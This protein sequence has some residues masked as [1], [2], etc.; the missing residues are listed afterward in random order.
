MKKIVLCLA[1]IIVLATGWAVHRHREN[2]IV[3]D[4]ARLA[5]RSVSDFPETVSHVFDEMDGA[6]PLSDAERKGRNTW[7]LWTAGDETFWDTMARDGAGIG[8]LLRAIDSRQRATRFHDGGMINQPGFTAASKPDRYGLWIDEGPQEPGVD[9]RVYGR[10]TGIVGLR[11]YPNPKF[12]AVAAARWSAEKYYRDPAYYKDRNLAR[13]YIVGMSCGFCHVAFNPERTPRDVENPQWSELSSTIGNQYLRASRVFAAGVGPDNFAMQVLQSWAP[14]TIDTSFLATDHLNN[15]STINSISALAA[16]MTAA[17]E[18][19]MGSGNM[20]FHGEQ[21]RMAVPHILKDGADSVGLIG[22]LSRVYVSIGEYSEEWLRDHDALV[23]ARSQR[24]FSVARAQ[25]C[26]IYWQATA[27]KLDNVARFLMLMKPPALANAVDCAAQPKASTEE[28]QHGREVFAAHCAQCHSSKQPDAK[29]GSPEYK[30]QMLALVSRPDFL[31]GN[32]LSTENRIP[33]SVVKTNAA[34]ALAT[35]AIRGHVWS[36]FSSDTYKSLPSAGQIELRN[37]FDG[38]LRTIT[39]PSGG[40]GYYR[41]PSLLGIWARAPL[42]HNNALGD[43][44]GDPSTAA[45]LR[46]YDD[47]MHKLLWPNTRIPHGLIRRTT[48]ESYLEISSATLP[49][50]L[51]WLAKDGTLRIG[52][53]PAGTPVDLIASADFEINFDRLAPKKLALLFRMQSMLLHNQDAAQTAARIKQIDA[54]LL[55]I[56]KCPDFVE[57]GGHTFGADLPDADKHALIE[58]MKTF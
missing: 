28:L 30:A 32:F 58:F 49:W 3:P 18:E 6:V 45:R 7:I 56:S 39:L 15:P 13:P 57:D 51:R 43:F 47:A 34:R 41:V 16:R 11:L 31:Q 48:A 8:D 23:G 5:G 44:T 33:V 42:L 55:A 35:N 53:I 14:G 19:D 50:E 52:P 25:Q 24:P 17:H 20:H 21:Q 36:D 46:A 1:I 26:S 27:M 2:A 9:P 38:S 29:R 12:G 40:P 54:D 22:A 4:A 10:P 37:P